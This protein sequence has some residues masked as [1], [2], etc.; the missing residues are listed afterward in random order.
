MAETSQS[1]G[2]V[3][4]SGPLLVR[5]C[6]LT[7]AMFALGTEVFMVAGLLPLIAADMRISLSFAGQL[8]TA[9][10]FIYA[11]ASPVAATLLGN[12][13]RQ[14]VMIGGLVVFACGNIMAATSHS[15]T[16]LLV[17]RILDALGGCSF[18]PVTL[19]IAAALAPPQWRGRALSMAT[20]G[21]YLAF[22]IGVPLSTWI[23]VH[24]DW[25]TAYWFL[26]AVTVTALCGVVLLLG[27][28]PKPPKVP[29]RERLRLL[30]DVPVLH[31]LTATVLWTMGNFIVYTYIAAVF[32]ALGNVQPERIAI[33]VLTYGV[34]GLVG[35]PLGGRLTDKYGP[36]LAVTGA[37][38]AI[39]AAFS[40]LSI[41][42]WMPPSPRPFWLGVA[43]VALW[44][45]ASS[46]LLPSQHARLVGLAPPGTTTI[47]LS[48]NISS[49]YFGM[50][51]GSSIGAVIIAASA[52]GYLGFAG[53]CVGVI[54]L[55]ILYGL[56]PNTKHRSAII[57]R[58]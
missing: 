28:V 51:I 45:A 44:G 4:S 39:I 2:Q 40:S 8:V 26:A 24:G 55:A 52:P 10:S 41:A 18:G 57:E 23:G 29:L 31:A 21:L 19:T 1:T 12:F 25:R 27:D 17:A 6:C 13:D 49:I 15:F 22:S 46:A 38:L 35:T 30:G 43:A 3:V 37:L 14:K 34:A 56:R 32:G 47:A 5:L 42:A 33:V 9:F 36:M 16:T 50:G 54:N 7:L 20:A 53:A 11:L 58:G 48:L